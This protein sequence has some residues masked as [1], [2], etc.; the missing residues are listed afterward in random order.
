MRTLHNL[1]PET[2]YCVQPVDDACRNGSSCLFQLAKCSEAGANLFGKELRLLPR[3]EVAA[4]VELVVVDEF[5]IGPLRPASRGRIDFVRE[6][7]H[8]DRDLDAPDV[9]EAS[10]GR[11]SRGV[12]V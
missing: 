12:P 4:F 7:A 11:N 1:A 9:K 5:G 6:G 3:R 2:D 8:G 10:S